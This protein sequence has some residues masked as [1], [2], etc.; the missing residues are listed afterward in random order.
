[1]LKNKRIGTKIA[2]G[3][4]IMVLVIAVVM[5]VVFV[6]MNGIKSDSIRMAD[7]YIEEVRIATSLESHTRD[8]MY[9][10]SNYAYSEESAYYDDAIR[11]IELTKEDIAQG[12]SLVEKYPLLVKLKEGLVQAETN[13]EV[14]E[15]LIADTKNAI[16]QKDEVRIVA[17]SSAALFV[18]NV[19]DYLASQDTKLKSQI[20]V[21]ESSNALISR[22][23]K[24]AEMN[25]VLDIGNEIRIAN[26]KAQSTGDVSHYEGIEN[27][28][29][30]IDRIGNMIKSDTS[31]SANL[32]QLSKVES[33][34][35]NYHESIKNMIVIQS[36][37]LT[38]KEERGAA[39][40]A[41][42][43]SAKNISNAGLTLSVEK[44]QSSVNSISSAIVTMIIGFII[45]I[46]LGVIINVY[47]IKKIVSDVK[48]ITEAA[49]KLAVGDIEADVN[50][51]SNDEIGMLG[52]AFDEMIKSIREQA[53]I[54]TNMSH[55]NL[56]L[57][58]KPKSE[59]DI[60]NVGLK[61][62]VEKINAIIDDTN[63]LIDS[64]VKGDLT[65]RADEE[66]H[67]GGYKKIIAGINTMLGAVI[68]PIEEAGDV[69]EKM[70]KG[71]FSARVKGDYKGDHAKIKNS[72]NSSMIA[73]QEMI[74]DVVKMLNYMADKDFSQKVT[75][76]YAGD[77]NK[78]KLAF[79][80]ILSQLNDVLDEINI[81]AE[82]VAT[83]SRQVSDSSQTLSQGSTEQASSIEQITAS[84]TEIAEQTKE[85]ALNAN[86]ASDLSVSSK[87]DA[88]E[89][90]VQMQE[91]VGAMAD[92]KESSTNISKIIKVIDDIAFQTN[93]LALN[94][95]VEAARAGE[96]GK[97]FAV[98]A[99]EVRNLAARS[100][101][102]AKETTTLIEESI[103]KVDEG[104]KIAN[105]TSESLN[106]I[107]EGV[108][109]T[110][111]IVGGIAKAS[112]EQASAITQVNEG[113]SQ[114]SKVVQMNTATSEETA[115]ASEEMN[116]QATLLRERVS[117]FELAKVYRNTTNNYTQNYDDK[118][119]Q[120]ENIAE[121]LNQPDIE[122][123]LDDSEFGKY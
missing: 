29:N 64:A 116:S 63:E 3:I 58:V 98:V 9:G 2:M 12:K 81:A 109:E 108:G 82:Q 122:I 39:G 114:V 26:F 55:G 34:M 95:A 13:L 73:T 68:E 84:I 44:A 121:P 78:I 40:N 60:L 1:M 94:A 72:L 91:M 43:E 21:A 101:D 36:K 123:N 11:A 96:H 33:S 111:E 8:I 88:A 103:L 74:K 46:V 119:A 65:A 67:E 5:G 80:T 102:A 48:K 93:I 52:D 41:M 69:L 20:R 87:T 66:R 49:Q 57:E 30:E 115:A 112:N 37:M 75:K 17:D 105:E 53:D 4:G 76:D 47:I 32:D 89:G 42:L 90:N 113:V 18:K 14:Y 61:A 6:S 25:D 97:G 92:I 79:N 7:E 24:I 104:T 118:P 117:E 22:V 85:N 31:Q 100:A 51:D 15:G 110:A 35:N 10:M 38:L 106:K 62:A 54:V 19:N 107:V 23:D 86:K 56:Q 83:A 50:I 59:K 77:W 70:A 120:V 99:E 16:E 27:K 71:D 28:F 45:A